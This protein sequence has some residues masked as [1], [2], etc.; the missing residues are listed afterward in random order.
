MD[1]F[2]WKKQIGRFVSCDFV[3]KKMYDQ[4]DEIIAPQSWGHQ[5]G[6][7]GLG[8]GTIWDLGESLKQKDGAIKLRIQWKMDENCWIEN[9]MIFHLII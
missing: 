1:I 2:A 7:V 5:R 8:D 6:W 3:A 4:T 9:I